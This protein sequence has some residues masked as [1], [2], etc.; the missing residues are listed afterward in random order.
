MFGCKGTRTYKGTG[1]RDK[2]EVFVLGGMVFIGLCMVF[3]IFLFYYVGKWKYFNTCRLKK[4][5]IS[6]RL[7]LLQSITSCYYTRF[8]TKLISFIHC[9]RCGLEYPVPFGT[10]VQYWNFK[11]DRRLDPSTSPLELPLRYT[12]LYQGVRPPYPYLS[13]GGWVIH[14]NISLF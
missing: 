3:V 5:L 1:H 8:K 13:L 9:G 6:S 7:L 2:N 12:Y 10:R 4:G 14:N 11:N